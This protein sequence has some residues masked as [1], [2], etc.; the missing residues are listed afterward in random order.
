M[1]QMNQEGRIFIQGIE[2]VAHRQQSLLQALE[3]AGFAP[4]Y[5]CRQ[6]WCGACKNTL[7]SGEV[8]YSSEPMAHLQSNEVLTCCCKA[9][10]NIELA[11][12]P[13]VS[14]LRA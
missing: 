12:L 14:Q 4:E 3:A 10:G 7:L 11:E 9:K 1:K 5:Q 2:I 13:A 6:G 8:E